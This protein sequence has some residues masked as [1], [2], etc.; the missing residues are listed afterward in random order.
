MRTGLGF[1]LITIVL[2]TSMLSKSTAQQPRFDHFDISKQLSQNNITHLCVDEIGYVW[3]ATLEGLNRFDGYRTE[4]FNNRSDR[5]GSFKGNQIFALSKGK[6]GNIWIVSNNGLFQY[7]IGSESFRLSEEFQETFPIEQTKF[8]VEDQES[9]LWLSNGQTLSW[10]DPMTGRSGIVEIGMEI[11]SMLAYNTSMLVSGNDGM[12]QINSQN[13]RYEVKRIFSQPVFELSKAR[14][15]SIYGINSSDIFEWPTLDAAPKNVYELEG[16]RLPP[17]T[18]D[19]IN[20]LVVKNNEIWIGGIYPLIYIDL[21]SKHT[22]V[23][24]YNK[25]NPFSFKGYIVRNLELDKHDN[26]WIGTSRHGLNL[27]EQRKNQFNHYILGR[28]DRDQDIDP[29]RSIL[30]TRSGDLWYAVDRFGIGLLMTTG[31]HKFYRNYYDCTGSDY[32]LKRVRSLYEDT[33]GNVWIGALNGLVEYNPASDQIQLVE[34]QNNWSWPYHA[35]SINEFERGELT[36]SGKP[37]HVGT[38]DL[39]EGKLTHKTLSMKKDDIGTIRDI[40]L[41]EK[42]NYWAALNNG[43]AKFNLDKDQV[44]YFTSDNSQL[45]N[46]KVYDLLAI[47]DTI[48]I[49]TNSGLNAFDAK[50]EKIVATYY[51]SDGL[52]NDIVYSLKADLDNQLWISTNNGISLFNPASSSFTSFL[53]EDHFLD[54]AHFQGD[55]G[56]IFFGGYEGITSFNPMEIESTKYQPE[57]VI[58]RLYLSNELIHPGQSVKDN[59]IL[60]QTVSKTKSISLHHTNNSFSL[61]FNAF[62][63]NYP[64]NNTFRYRLLGQNDEWIYP[65]RSNRLATYSNLTP[66]EYV[67]EAQVRQGQEEWGQSKELIINIIPAIWQRPWFQYLLYLLVVA[68]IYI[69]Y[70]LRVM[71]IRNRNRVLNRQVKEQTSKLVAKNQQILEQKNEIE[72]IARKLHE[73]DQAKLRF[74]TNISHEFRTPLTLILGQLEYLHGTMANRAAKS[75]KNNALRLHRLVEQ[76][77]D[78]RKLDRDQMKLSVSNLDIVSFTLEIVESFRFAAQEKQIKINFSSQHKSLFLWFDPD[79]M[80]KILYNLIS[81]ALKYSSEDKNIYLTITKSENDIRISGYTVFCPFCPDQTIGT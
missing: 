20:A 2:L 40:I 49:G 32:E 44:K 36:L 81:N 12:K 53:Q 26:L 56:V 15:G 48:W 41:D 78:I 16:S 61:D 69:L 46:N 77:I 50:T 6:D 62:P 51:E 72:V 80:D 57:V 55:D 14:N 19:N 64:N 22:E 24:T 5:T 4:K 1:L 7:E 54:D 71:N 9:I 28:E 74:F 60:E 47:N 73:A 34:C 31:E 33:F 13:G 21:Q 39:K 45:S 76:L 30:R 29:I 52:V 38:V 79:K 10:F 17:I 42:G 58:E 11:S 65:I 8:L 18:S 43:M 67:L 3:I 70:R 25:N 35:Y 66:K 37:N 68:A 27:L 59:V 63:F 23:Y 75:I